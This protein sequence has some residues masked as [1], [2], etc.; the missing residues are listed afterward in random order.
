MNRQKRD[1]FSTR[2]KDYGYDFLTKQ[3]DTLP[4]DKIGLGKCE[5]V[6]DN[7]ETINSNG[8]F[9]VTR[10]IKFEDYGYVKFVGWV[11][12]YSEDGIECTDFDSY[13][14]VQPVQKVV[15][16]YEP[17]P[18][19]IQM[20]FSDIKQMLESDLFNNNDLSPHVWMTEDASW[21]IQ[22]N[23]SRP[24]KMSEIKQH[25]DQLGPFKVVEQVGGEGQGNTYFAVYHF[26]EHDI[27]VKF[28]GWYSSYSGT[29]YEDM[30]EVFPTEVTRT[31][32][33][34]KP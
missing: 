9:E 15:T 5:I 32:Y 20:T 3:V 2:I 28:G 12:S 21:T 33:L 29:E 30:V 4:L 31:E 19:S 7:T 13:S 27:Y 22:N 14:F 8:I 17:I 6:E 26:E 25:L 16:V 1:E 24:G 11:S 23:L 10:I 18:T 34:P